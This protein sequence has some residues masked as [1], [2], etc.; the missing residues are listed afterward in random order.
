MKLVTFTDSVRVALGWRQP[1][2]AVILLDYSM[3]RYVIVRNV[4]I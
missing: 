2:S 1:E 4:V 3:A